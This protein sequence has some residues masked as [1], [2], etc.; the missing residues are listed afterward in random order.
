[1]IMRILSKHIMYPYE[2]MKIK[3]KNKMR[4]VAVPITA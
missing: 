4:R 3:K 2:I 1:M